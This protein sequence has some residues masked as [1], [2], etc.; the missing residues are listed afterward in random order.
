M[1]FTSINASREFP[2]I[3]GIS[4]DLAWISRFPGNFLTGKYGNP[5][6]NVVKS[7]W[8]RSINGIKYS[9]LNSL[10]RENERGLLLTQS[11]LQL[12]CSLELPQYVHWVKMSISESNRCE[13]NRRRQ[14]DSTWLLLRCWK[15]ALT[16]LK[17]CSTY[18]SRSIIHNDDK[19]YLNQPYN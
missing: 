18:Y 13:S 9:Y 10:Q 2:G 6:R 12:V 4:R 11:V 17:V 5:R 15:F 7:K 1:Y 3:P 14:L 16:R 8:R 19:K